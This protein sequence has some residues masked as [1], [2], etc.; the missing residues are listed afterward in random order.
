MKRE[1]FSVEDGKIIKNGNE[2]FNG[3]YLQ[4]FMDE[5]AGVICDDIHTQKYLNDF[6]KGDLKLESGRIYL[7]EKRISPHDARKCLS[8]QVTFIDKKSKLID[9]ITMEENI[10]LFTDQSIFV[11]KHKYKEHFSALQKKFGITLPVNQR[12]AELTAKDRI[13]VELMKAFVE[14]KR[15]VVLDD[16]SGYLQKKEVEE[17]YSLL[18]ILLKYDMT[19]LIRI[20]FEDEYLP[21]FN[22][23]TVMKGNKTMS[24]LDPSKQDIQAYT[25]RLF[26]D[27]NTVKIG[28][29]KNKLNIGLKR[30]TVLEFAGVSTAYLTD[31]NFSLKQGMLLKIQCFDDLSCSQVVELLKGE[32]KPISGT[33]LFQHAA[34]RPGNI[35]SATHKGIC[36]I[37]Q[38]A[39]DSMLFQ[40][41]SLVENL[42]IPCN[43]KIKNFWLHPKYQD[44]IVK[45]LENKLGK[46]AL[47]L[48]TRKQK[49]S[50]L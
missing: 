32:L 29:K 9:T 35:Y 36:F 37:E 10:F 15:L 23:V 7:N 28:L 48:P 17:V 8:R 34:Y 20:G 26:F 50:V 44:S 39:Y 27:E 14:R 42:S 33:I 13:V 1:L 38:S 6:L 49:S 31:I 12:L 5:V 30:E 46:K 3:L 47:K 41:M 43:E 25:R 18:L 11:N 22:R 19:F 45:Q 16:I 21:Q 2:I 4:I 24:V 40:N